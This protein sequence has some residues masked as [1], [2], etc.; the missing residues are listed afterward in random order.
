MNIKNK[1]QFIIAMILIFVL[2]GILF[3]FSDLP[4]MILFAIF[5]MG[6]WFISSLF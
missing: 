4:K 5:I 2:F 1:K 3:Y 6:A